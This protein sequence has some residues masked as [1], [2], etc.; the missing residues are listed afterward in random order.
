[1]LKP[2]LIPVLLCQNNALV[3]TVNFDEGKYIGD[4]INAVR[5]FNEKMVDE[6]C[7]CDISDDPNFLRPN[8]KLIEK[9]SY[10]CRMPLLY[11]GGVETIEEI[12]KL[13]SLG[14]EKVGVGLGSGK[15]L[16]LISEATRRLGNQSI[17]GF[18]NVKK[19]NTGYVTYFNNGSKT[20]GKELKEAINDGHEAGVGEFVINSIDL[21][22]RMLGF[23]EELIERTL[24]LANQTPV[25]V[26]GGAGSWEDISGVYKKYGLIGI[27]VGSL[28]VFKGPFKAVLINYPDVEKKAELMRK[29]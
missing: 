14:V 17:A 26:V 4:P 3:K 8:F 29:V 11:A 15:R 1:M 27:G 13:I 7:F 25:T 9:L 28:C 10:E 21:D 22:G 24:S 6:L 23:D 19:T 20:I 16:T 12:E 18:I 5:I 2:R